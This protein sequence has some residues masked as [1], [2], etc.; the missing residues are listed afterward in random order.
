MDKG[1][2]GG[3]LKGL[4]YVLL[5]VDDNKLGGRGGAGGIVEVVWYVLLVEPE[6]TEDGIGGAGGILDD[7]WLV[8]L[9]EDDKND[10]GNG[11][12]GGIFDAL[13]EINGVE[14]IP[15]NRT[16]IHLKLTYES[17]YKMVLWESVSHKRLLT[18]SFLPRET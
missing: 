5:F 7:V 2:G 8:L 17:S 15:K 3:L 18:R 1:A 13:G 9:I 10:G 16:E 14:A 4:W 6:T 11:G 12:G